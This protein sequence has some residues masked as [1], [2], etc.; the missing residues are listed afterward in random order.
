MFRANPF[1]N[2]KK[3]H[4]FIRFKIIFN[5]IV[6]SIRISMFLSY[7]NKRRVEALEHLGADEYVVSSN[8]NPMW[9]RWRELQIALTTDVHSFQ[10]SPFEFLH[11]LLKEANLVGAASRTL[12]VKLILGKW[13]ANLPNFILIFYTN[14]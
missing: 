1:F 8:S 11:L 4:I 9:Q 2:L 5:L 10:F 14:I 3:I 6:F 7:S 13:I 12:Q